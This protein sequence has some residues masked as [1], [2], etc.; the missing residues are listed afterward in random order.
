MNSKG[1]NVVEGYIK[2]DEEII[3]KIEIINQNGWK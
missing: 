2:Y 3:E 1:I